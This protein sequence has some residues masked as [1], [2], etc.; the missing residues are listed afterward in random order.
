MRIAGL[1]V[2]TLLPVPPLRCAIIWP[3]PLMNKMPSIAEATFHFFTTTIQIPF[4]SLALNFTFK[5]GASCALMGRDH[6]LKYLQNT[7]EHS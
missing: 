1:C 6:T 7:D 5:Q 2:A 4:R 3:Q